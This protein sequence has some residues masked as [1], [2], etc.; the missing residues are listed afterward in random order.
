MHTHQKDQAVQEQG[1]KEADGAGRLVGE[2]Q[3]ALKAN[4]GDVGQGCSVLLS[5]EVCRRGWGVGGGLLSPGTNGDTQ[6]A[7]VSSLGACMYTHIR[8]SQKSVSGVRC[9]L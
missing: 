1:V 7:K 6:T 2:N 9:L 4:K 3:T 8:G 5:E